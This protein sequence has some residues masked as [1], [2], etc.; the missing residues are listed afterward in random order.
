MAEELSRKWRMD[1]VLETFGIKDTT[2]YNRLHHL[3]IK[4]SK[5]EEGTYISAEQ[6]RL[7]EQLNEHIK[8]TGKMNGF[9]DSGGQL[10]L[11]ESSGLA[12]LEIPEMEAETFTEMDDE[13][14]SQLIE[15]AGDLKVQQIAMPHLVRLHLANEMTEED[16]SDEQKAKL[17]AVRAAAHPKQ[18]AAPIAQGLLERHRSRKNQA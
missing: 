6:M 4:A 11:S 1:E 8:Q 18:N 10:A 9:G 3:K 16:L 14:V 7:M 17:Q 5:D 12:A 15:E 13:T 2:Y